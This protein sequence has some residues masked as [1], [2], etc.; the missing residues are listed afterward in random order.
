MTYQHTCIKVSCGAAYEDTDPDDY[1]CEKCQKK[2]K[3]IAAKIDAQ[4]AGKIS[5][6]KIITPLQEYD[7]APKVNGLVRTKL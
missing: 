3:A 6:R 1:Y 4:L 5:K 7:N 2:A